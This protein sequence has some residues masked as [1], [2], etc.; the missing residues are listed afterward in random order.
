MNQL[1]NNK[2]S[3]CAKLNYILIIILPVT[4]FIGS[5]ISN[6]TVLFI[7]V[8]FIIDLIKKKNFFLIKDFNFKFLLI[9][10]GYLII[11]SLF[12]S[13]NS[14]SLFKTVVFIRFFIL[15]YALYYYF[16]LFKN[17]FLKFWF[18][19]FLIVSLDILFEFYVG[20]NILGFSSVYHGR[21]ASFSGDELKVGGFYFGFLFIS[22][23]FL[24]DKK[25]ALFILF[26]SFFFIIALLI[27][28]RSNFLKVLLMYIF[29]FMLFVDISKMKKLF[30]VALLIIVSTII[31]NSIPQL[32]GKFYYHVFKT[33]AKELENNKKLDY[34]TII[35]KNQYLSH[36]YTALMISK[37]NLLFGSG[38]KTFRFE[39]YKEKYTKKEDGFI[40][41]ASTH[42][43]QTHFELLAEI[44][45]IGYLLIISNLIFILYRQIKLDKSFL[46]KSS[47]LFIL[48]SLV[49][50][51]PSG[52]FFTS[53]GATIFFINYSFLIRLKRN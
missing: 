26:S 5:L 25:K 41:G 6:L 24:S 42:P 33:Y 23:C 44:G 47:I 49:P 51:L 18:I 22:L 43:H 40:F 4:L 38:F 48:A 34:E 29:F 39:S 27:G 14:E 15:S 1:L 31:I 30:Y 3:L 45:I 10:Y 46:T 28:E 11:N 37:D 35:K 52:S 16:D 7:C 13:Y 53:Y 32:K 50:L 2:N 17:D 20:K 19:I 9:I 8:L 21:I 36:Y 12:V